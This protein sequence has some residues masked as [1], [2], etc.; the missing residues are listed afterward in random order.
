MNCM[1]RLRVSWLHSLSVLL[2]VLVAPLGAQ[3]VATGTIQ[4]VITDPTGAAIPKATV[5]VQDVEINLA[6]TELTGN[7]GAY[8]FPDLPVGNYSVKVEM[9]GFQTVTHT[10]ITLD[11]AQHEVVNFALPVGVAEQQI[12]VTTAVAQVD[13]TSGSVGYLVDNH[14]IADL[15]LNGRSFV[16]LA[17]LQAGT[18]Q[19]A[20]FNSVQG[21]V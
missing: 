15:P 3:V 10:G 5:T 1:R 13:T 17:L 14:Q 19:Y 8:L 2:F 7:D 9:T 18:A 16:S 4:G 21:L 20:N 11:V 6:R 12:T